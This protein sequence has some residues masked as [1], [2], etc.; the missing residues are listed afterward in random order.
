M[1]GNFNLVAVTTATTP[2]DTVSCN[3]MLGPLANNGGATQTMALQTGSCAI[4]AASPT[5][6]ETSDQRGFARPAVAATNADIGAYESGATDPD[7][8]FADTFGG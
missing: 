1:T 3:P 4:D 8:I 7:K 6:S 5:P 2:S